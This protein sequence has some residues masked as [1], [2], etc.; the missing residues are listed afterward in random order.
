MEGL[1]SPSP[2][3]PGAGWY[4][5][6]T[7]HGQRFWD[8]ARWTEHYAPPPGVA[9]A[10]QDDDPNKVSNLIGGILISLLIPIVGVIVGIVW[11]AKGRTQQGLIFLGISLVSI[12]GYVALT[13]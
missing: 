9:L 4:P 8:G 11:L 10:Q 7:G 1:A 3:T 12:L 6:P 13:A 5:D 2:A